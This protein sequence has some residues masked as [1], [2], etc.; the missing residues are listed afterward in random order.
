MPLNHDPLGIDTALWLFDDDLRECDPYDRGVLFDLM[1]M[2]HSCTPYGV[3]VHNGAAVPEERIAKR[4]GITVDDWR[5]S[6]ARLLMARRI[7]LDELTGAV[8]IPRMVKEMKAAQVAKPS[9]GAPRKRDT[10]PI[11]IPESL[12]SNA[13]FTAA[14]DQWL[15]YRASIRRPL[16]PYTAKLQLA[17]LE[18]SGEEA[19]AIIMQSIERQWVG[20][21][22]LR[23]SHGNKTQDSQTAPRGDAGRQGGAAAGEYRGAGT[24]RRL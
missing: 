24:P 4:I 23:T 11:V 2:A 19:V 20:L 21:F 17:T 16:N 15:K 6:R 9:R 22:A 7:T 14:W 18:A 3:L 12:A 1:C 13:A 10:E 5:A 8:Q